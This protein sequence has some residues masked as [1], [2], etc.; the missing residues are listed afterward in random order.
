MNN[1]SPQEVYVKVPVEKEL[2]SVPGYYGVLLDTEDK[3]SLFGT[4]GITNE[5]QWM[6]EFV[7]SQI[8]KPT[9]WLKPL[10]ER[11][12]LTIEELRWLWQKAWNG[13]IAWFDNSGGPADDFI[14]DSET[15]F[16][17]LIKPQ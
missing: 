14:P 5:K 12:V 13:G 1:L 3:S 7:P 9:H 15:L 17:Q 10:P 8:R 16:N 2:P 6:H 11:F 4:Q